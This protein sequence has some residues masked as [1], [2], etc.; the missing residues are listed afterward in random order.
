MDSPGAGSHNPAGMPVQPVIG[1]APPLS[2]LLLNPHKITSSLS[3]RLL[4]QAAHIK[5]PC[6]FFTYCTH[7]CASSVT[8]PPGAVD[9]RYRVRTGGDAGGRQF[10]YGE[11]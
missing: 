11:G 5:P 9:G 3:A 10:Y 2:P 7:P 4:Y 8:V 6:S 1:H